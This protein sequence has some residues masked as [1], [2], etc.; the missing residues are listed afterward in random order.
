MSVFI[1]TQKAG[2]ADGL[3]VQRT[4]SVKKYN[5]ASVLGRVAG[6]TYVCA[7]GI[8]GGY[9]S[10]VDL[11]GDGVTDV[12]FSSP[13]EWVLSLRKGVPRYAEVDDLVT[14]A[15]DGAEYGLAAYTARRVR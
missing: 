12:T 15:H 13:V 8:A 1:Y 7:T 11:D 4:L 14:Y 9:G 6:T 10:L 3:A 5:Y 2:E